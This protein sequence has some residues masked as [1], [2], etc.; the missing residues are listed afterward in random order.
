MMMVIL[1]WVNIRGSHS[2][3][4]KVGE[5]DFRAIVGFS[6]RDKVVNDGD[7]TVVITPREFVC[8]V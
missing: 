4:I 6:G 8:S 3:G 2:C 1:V 7:K 5:G